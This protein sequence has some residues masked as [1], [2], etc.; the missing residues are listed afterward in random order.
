MN[1][2][3]KL[4]P[5][6]SQD[7]PS[8]IPVDRGSG[9]ILLGIYVGFFVLISVGF[10]MGGTFGSFAETGIT[11]VPLTLLATLAY[12]GRSSL[13]GRLI[14]LIWLAFLALG[15]AVL[16]FGMVNV[17]VM[18]SEIL[19]GGAAGAANADVSSE[20]LSTVGT[21][22]LYTG[23]VL[24]FSLLGFVPALRRSLSRI[25]PLDPNSFVHTVALVAVTALSLVSFVPLLVLGEPALLTENAL[26][27][28]GEALGEGTDAL[29][30]QTYT[31]VWII[32]ASIV[33]VGYGLRRNLAD[34]FARLGLEWPTFRQVGVGIATALV[35]VVLVNLLEPGMAWVW[36]RM[37]WPQTD[38]D[39][40][41]ELLSFAF[42]PLGAVVIGVTAGLGE[43]LGVR[44]I[45]QPRLGIFLSNLFF[46]SLHALQYNWD[47]LLVVFVLGMVFGVLRKRTNTSTSAIAHGVYNFT[48]IMLAVYE[49]SLFGGG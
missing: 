35:L 37:G 40:F 38:G 21:T 11:F 39:A 36:E 2:Q 17:A 10:A 41:G 22:T 48:L 3:M 7:A 44:G 14:T 19:S 5:S 24:L 4:D 33:A 20:L 6:A 8:L 16:S 28:L 47:A 13:P 46:T 49:I 30:T 15:M 32:P 27:T 18:P 43:E 29:L 45:L 26:A 42:S 25:V 31:L 9:W 23:I 1:E 12:M 34:A